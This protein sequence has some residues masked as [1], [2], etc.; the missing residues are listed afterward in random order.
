MRIGLKALLLCAVMA[1]VWSNTGVVAAP[2]DVRSYAGGRFALEID[3]SAV[4]F[5]NTVDGGLAFGDVVRFAGEEFFFKKQ[6]GNA[7]FRDIRLEVGADMD[8]SFY[9]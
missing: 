1:I 8:K 2:P 3:G 4:G 5:V 7:G 6:L 9:N